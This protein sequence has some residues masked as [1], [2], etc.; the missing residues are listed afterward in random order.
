MA[1]NLGWKYHAV[2]PKSFSGLGGKT[3]DPIEKYAFL[4]NRLKLSDFSNKYPPHILRR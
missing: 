3:L 1:E 2:W 4:S